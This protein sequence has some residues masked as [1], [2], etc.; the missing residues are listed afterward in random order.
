M[1]ARNSYLLALLSG[2]LLLLSLPPF[3]FG[4][5]LAWFAL[6]P[7]LIAV[8]YENG[9]KRVGRLTKI[10]ALG[11][12]PICIW[13]AWWVPDLSHALNLEHLF[14]LWFVLGL[15]LAFILTQMYYGDFIGEYYKPK[16]LPSKMM[17]YLPAGLTFIA[18][19]VIWTAIEFLALNIPVVMRIL[20]IYGFGS[21]AK[22]QWL[23][24]AI[25]R[26]SSFT[27]MYGV[28][29]L[30]VL[31]NCAI[32]YGMIKYR[33]TH[34]IS[35]GA[36]AVLAIFAFVFVYGAV[37]IPPSKQGDVTAAIIQIPQEAED[38]PQR[39]LNFSEESLEYEPQFVMWPMLI[40]VD[41]PPESHLKFARAHNV[42][43]FGPLPE[44][45]S[46]SGEVGSHNMGYHMVTLF[47][48]IGKADVKGIFCPEVEGIDTEFGK[49]G[50]VVCIESGST[51]PARD[52]A[53]KEAQFLIV[54]TGGPNV[55][56]FSWALGTNAIYRAAENHM[57]AACPIGDRT[58]SM[59]IDPY[60]RIIEDIAPEP[61]IVA[62]KIAFTSERTFYS[63]YGDIFGWT[64]VGLFIILIGYNLYLKRKSP[65]V[66]CKKCRTQIE[67]GAKVCPECGKKQ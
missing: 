44:V 3:R 16:R 35:K 36:V 29:F 65:Y 41:F 18:L 52:L 43:V 25:L 37:T 38:V 5:Y 49:V 63:K 66:F 60:G 24:P 59:L 56:V 39:Y 64:V 31:V 51:L 14:W 34:R 22:T 28:T 8:F 12:L 15:G 1:I 42:H 58:G 40:T 17:T 46:P 4:T 20:N 50:I 57:F 10:A 55:S 21:I 13:A 6:V 45:V 19:P 2:V 53:G 61:E 26:L 62:G 30:V 67:K 9:G 27:G 11:A 7:I 32:A 48:Q 54:N 33:E 47:Q 23:N